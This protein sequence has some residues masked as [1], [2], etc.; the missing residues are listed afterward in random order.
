MSTSKKYFSRILMFSYYQ[1]HLIYYHVCV[2]LINGAGREGG[3]APLKH[4]GISGYLR[5]LQPMERGDLPTGPEDM[6]H[7]ENICVDG[8]NIKMDQQ[9]VGW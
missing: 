4:R 3:I 5:N 8:D 2:V 1:I 7:F 6:S 9:E